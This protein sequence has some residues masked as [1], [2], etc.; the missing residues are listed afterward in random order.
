MRNSNRN[1]SGGLL[2]SAFGLLEDMMS[3]QEHQRTVLTDKTGR[4]G[5]R[6]R[7]DLD[8]ESESTGDEK[9]HYGRYAT[10]G[11]SRPKSVFSR[12]KSKILDGKP[13]SKE[14]T[15]LERPLE[16]R[17]SHEREQ[18]T[19]RAEKREP[20]QRTR[21]PVQVVD[22]DR[23]SSSS[24]DDYFEIHTPRHSDVDNSLIQAL[25]NAV[26]VQRRAV[27]SCKRR[28]EQAS[29]Q[30][31][32]SSAHLQRVVDDIK[33]HEIALAT[34]TSSLHKAKSAQR[35]S[36]VPQQRP[37]SFHPRSAYE[38]QPASAAPPP[39][40]I[41]EHFVFTPYESGFEQGFN[42]V[43][44][45]NDPIFSAFEQLQD[46]GPFVRPRSY[47]TYEHLFSN[48]LPNPASDAYFHFFAMPGS[49]PR[50]TQAKRN[51]HSYAPPSSTYAPPPPPPQSHRHSSTPFQTYAP[52]VPR[53][54]V[55][56]LKPAEA[57][58]LFKTYT[59]RWNALSPLDPNI[60]YPTRTLTASSLSARDTLYAPNVSFPTSTWSE[61]TIMQANA[62]AFYL[63]VVGLKPTY[64]EVAG[65]GRVECGFDKGKASPTQVEELMGLLKKE[66]TR[67]HSDRLGRR[68]GGLVGGGPNEGLQKD[69]R[70]RA[71]FHAVC[72]LMERAAA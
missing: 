46:F 56:L 49:P 67:W 50:S 59:D 8:L 14:R 1:T 54:P 64:T 17:S 27:K 25:E 22:R 33:S 18:T 53:P 72:E 31:D 48:D 30:S 10:G 6:R 44:D 51:R 28:L 70:A 39:P 5:G 52:P 40:P 29:R 55:N 19:Y 16:E 2:G 61:E 3:M 57:A 15:S 66:K 68:N 47:G 4:E 24:E 13:R 43:H 45:I 9:D 20:G 69:V 63:G 36:A 21:P 35:R 34:A 37:R 65:T 11:R 60:L 26:D 23:I 42:P 62:Q 71:V 58:R 41:E 38:R 32:I 12:I 7:V